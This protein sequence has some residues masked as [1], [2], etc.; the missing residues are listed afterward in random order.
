MALNLNNFKSVLND[1]K[2]YMFSK[3]YNMQESYK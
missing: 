1:G 2:Y 3:W